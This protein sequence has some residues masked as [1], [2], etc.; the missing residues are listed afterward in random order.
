MNRHRSVAI[1]FAILALVPLTAQASFRTGDTELDALLGS[2]NVEAKANLG[3]FVA[4]LSAAFGYPQAEIEAWLNV[5]K[6]E[7]ADAY[8]ALNLA[9]LSGKT[10][11][12]VVDTYKKNRR[13]GWGAA[14]RSV[15]VKPGSEQFKALKQDAGGQ[16]EKARGRK[17]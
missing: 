16:A 3:P 7:P 9:K 11:Q 2:I 8:F 14:A 17:K 4:E 13:R 1:A 10:P 6:L 5:D 12:R 15:G